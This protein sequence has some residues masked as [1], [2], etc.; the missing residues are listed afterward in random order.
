MADKLGLDIV[1]P[2][3]IETISYEE[4]ATINYNTNYKLARLVLPT[5]Q[6]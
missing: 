4:S 1:P 2:E 6:T 5:H 3:I